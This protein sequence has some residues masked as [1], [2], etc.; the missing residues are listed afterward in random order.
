ME[1][2]RKRGNSMEENKK[3]RPEETTVDI[4]GHNYNWFYVCSECRCIVNWKQE[5]CP[6]CKR[7]INWNE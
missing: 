4:E 5:Y 6:E 2:I 1:I 3:D 7:R